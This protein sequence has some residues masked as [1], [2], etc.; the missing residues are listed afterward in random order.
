MNSP[1]YTQMPT[2]Q[3]FSRQMQGCIIARVSPDVPRRLRVSLLE[4]QSRDPR[5]MRSV[6][7]HYLT[8]DNPGPQ[9]PLPCLP[10]FLALFFF[11]CHGLFHLQTSE[12]N[13]SST[14][15][16]PK[17]VQRD[18]V[19]VARPGQFSRSAPTPI[20]RRDC[21]DVEPSRPSQI[22]RRTA[23]QPPLFAEPIT[24]ASLR[25]LIRLSRPQLP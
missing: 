24:R 16:R 17:V 8:S 3:T 23:V 13:S 22:G 11:P 19:S 15:L 1:P 9:S 6:A 18:S 14:I 12:V 5:S 2:T 20:Q 21:T 7:Q 25:R 10:A 4:R